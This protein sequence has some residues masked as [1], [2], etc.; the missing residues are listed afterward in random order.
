MEILLPVASWLGESCVTCGFSLPP[1]CLP[2]LAPSGVASH[3]F[4]LLY[5]KDNVLK[6]ASLSLVPSPCML[7]LSRDEPSLVPSF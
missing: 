1:Q 5:A 3:K 2:Q 7:A 4:W 6:M